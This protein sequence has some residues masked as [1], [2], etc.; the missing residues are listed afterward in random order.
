M[1]P[2]PADQRP[3]RRPAA[4]ARAERPVEVVRRAAGRARRVA[5]DHARRAQSDHRSQWRRQDDAVQSHQR[6]FPGDVRANPAVRPGRDRLAELPPRHARHGADLPGHQPVSETD[7]A[8]QCAL[9]DQGPARVEI[10][11]V[12]IFNVLSRGLRQGSRFSGT[13]RLHRSQRPRG[14]Q[15]FAWRAAPAR[16]RAGPGRRSGHPVARR[17]GGR[18]CRPANRRRWRAFFRSSMPRLRC[19]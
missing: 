9:G 10:R 17:A 7:R 13:R 4:S 2:D 11:D 15:S 18:V 19:C 16:N 12:A 14:T 1:K 5:D 8:R 6:H 3:N